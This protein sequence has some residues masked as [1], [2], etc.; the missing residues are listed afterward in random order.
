MTVTAR[1]RRQSPAE[2]AANNRRGS[3]SSELESRLGPWGLG[4]ADTRAESG[5]SE[6]AVRT[7]AAVAGRRVAEQLVVIQRDGC[8]PGATLS[9][10]KPI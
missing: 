1:R 9:N 10:S 2:A 4:P 3:S 5:G 7:A 6:H 8:T